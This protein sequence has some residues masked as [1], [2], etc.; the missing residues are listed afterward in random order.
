MGARYRQDTGRPQVFLD[1]RDPD[2]ADREARPCLDQVVLDQVRGGKNGRKV[3]VVLRVLRVLA[4]RHRRFPRKRSR[5]VSRCARFGQLKQLWEARVDPTPEELAAAA[6]RASRRARPPI[7][8][9]R[10]QIPPS[11]TG[12]S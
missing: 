1:H 3:L 5:A 2:A 10:L 12:Q 7:P 6:R 8:R 4:R 9:R 11:G